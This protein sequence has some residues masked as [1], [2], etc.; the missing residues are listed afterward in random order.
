MRTGGTRDSV[1]GGCSIHRFLIR[2]Y[3]EITRASKRRFSPVPRYQ[4]LDPAD[5]PHLP[6]AGNRH[7][8]P[9]DNRQ[10]DTAGYPQAILET[11]SRSE[12]K[13]L[14]ATSQRDQGALDI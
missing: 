5:H 11:D 12:S 2:G 4:H 6:P 8:T 1:D 9:A 14:H 7:S 3:E 13:K 10:L